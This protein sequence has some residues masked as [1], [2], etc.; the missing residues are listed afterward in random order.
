MGALL[1]IKNLILLATYPCNNASN[2]Y[3]K[4]MSKN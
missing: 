2:Q 4:I 1:C 3:N